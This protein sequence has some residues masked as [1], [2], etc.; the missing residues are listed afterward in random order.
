MTNIVVLTPGRTGSQLIAQNLR[1]G[2]WQV[3]HTHNPLYVPVDPETIGLFSKRHDEFGAIMSALVAERT[4]EYVSYTN[5]P[6][7]PFAISFEEFENYYTYQKLFFQVVNKSKYKNIIEIY[8]EDIISDDLY[9]F[10]QFGIDRKM[11]FLVDKSP[12]QYAELVTNIKELKIFLDE[13]NSK[14]IHPS[15]LP[16][17]IK[18]IEFDLTEDGQNARKIE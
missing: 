14:P 13:L 9:L 15:V 2:G 3:H 5:K 11:L 6:I 12:Y 17:F 16:E 10:R 18:T 8:Y 7:V 1:M 4:K